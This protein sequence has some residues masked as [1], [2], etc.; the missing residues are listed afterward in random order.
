MYSISTTKNS[1]N[2]RFIIMNHSQSQ[3]YSLMKICGRIQ[4]KLQRVASERVCINNPLTYS[5][6]FLFNNYFNT[7]IFVLQII[8]C[9]NRL[10]SRIIDILKINR[11]LNYDLHLHQHLTSINKIHR[12]H[13]VCSRLYAWRMQEWNQNE[14]QAIP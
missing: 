14:Y 7:N 3:N 4:R 11:M 13:L 6:I 9:C 1:F 2:L 5:S 10:P 8:C 12:F